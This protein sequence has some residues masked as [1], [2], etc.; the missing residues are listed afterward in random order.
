MT[1]GLNV[2]DFLHLRDL[3]PGASLVDGSSVIRRLMSVHTPWEIAQLRAACEAADWIHDQ[4][5]DLLR[6]GMTERELLDLLEA[7]FAD[8]YREPYAYSSTGAW[9][10]RNGSDPASMNAFHAIATD[11]AYRS[12]DV[13][14]RGYSGVGLNGYIA[15]TDRVWAVGRP[16]KAVVDL[17]RMTWECN[18]AMAVAIKPGVMGADIYAAGARVEAQHAYPERRTGRTGHGLRNTGGL[19]VHPDNRT[20]LEPGM[21]ISVEP[22]FPTVHGFFDLEDQYLVTESGAECLHRPR[23]NNFQSSTGTPI[24]LA[25]GGSQMSTIIRDVRILRPGGRLSPIPAGSKSATSE[26]LPSARVR[27]RSVDLKPI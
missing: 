4:T 16:S 6:P 7:R 20:V 21:V 9:D 23:P 1:L 10:V 8:R 14:M 19:S 11:R 13:V 5:Q 25:G 18:R 12:G 3:M 22:M 17:Y 24:S 26:S 2:L 15:D 27:C